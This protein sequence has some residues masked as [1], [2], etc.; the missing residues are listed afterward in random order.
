MIENHQ[1]IGPYYP[2][3]APKREREYSPEDEPEETIE[4]EVMA[5]IAHPCVSCGEPATLQ[6]HY[7]DVN[8][9]D[10]GAEVREG[11]AWVCETCL[12]ELND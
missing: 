9:T 11:D 2:E 4:Q 3:P 1:V 10:R 5:S 6:Q 8:Y 12:E 7:R